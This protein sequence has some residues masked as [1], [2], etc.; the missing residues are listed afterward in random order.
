M[1]QIVYSVVAGLILVLGLESCQQDPLTIGESVVSDAPFA[2]GKAVYDVFAFNKSIEAIPTNGLPLYQLGVMHHPIFGTSE[3]QITTQVQLADGIGKPT[4]GIYSQL[5]EDTDASAIP[6]NETITSVRLYLP[7]FQSRI[8]DKDLDGVI[9]LLDDAPEDSTNDSDGD[10]L[11]NAQEKTFG[12]NPLDQDTDGDGITDDE[13]TDT[14]SNTFPIVRDIDSIYGNRN[15]QFNLKVVRSTYFLD[16]LDPQSGYQE[17]PPNYSNVSLSTSFSGETLFDGEVT[18]SDKDFISFKEDDAETADVDES[19]QIDER[20]APGVMVELDSLFFQ[21]NLLDMEGSLELLSNS[22]FK[23]FFRG[24]HLSLTPAAQEELMMLL[25]LSAARITLFYDYDRKDSDGVI[26]RQ[27]SRYDMRLLRGGGSQPIIGS[28][29]NTIIKTGYPTEVQDALA[30]SENASRIYLKGGAGTYAELDLF[31][32]LGGGEIINEIKQKNWIINAAYLVAYVDR[33]RLDQVGGVEE[34]PRLYLYNAET[35]AP[36]YN[37]VTE[38][39]NSES[40]FGVY[41]NY[42]GFLQKEDGKGKKYLMNITEH[43]NNIVVRDSVNATLGL[44]ITPDLRLSG[45]ADVLL[46]DGQNTKKSL[47]VSANLSPLGTVLYGSELDPEN[48]TRLTLEIYYTEI[49]P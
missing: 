44:T 17:L 34:P 18:I 48:P 25:D 39:V 6:E 13:D 36:L 22:N 4:F 5:S 47:P 12:T 8:S 27:K 24:I 49:D 38:I 40:A 41:L 2:T 1:K 3:G 45:V 10:G 15:Q 23:N 35:N 11:S 30:S 26:S 16:D 9:D 33:D 14:A 19:L 7:F 32:R 29:V 43:I 46:G 42:N 31:D 37:P 21:Q 20:L 28:A